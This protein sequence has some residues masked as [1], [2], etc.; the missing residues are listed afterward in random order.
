MLSG[1]EFEA[2]DLTAQ[3]A[4]KLAEVVGHGP[5]RDADLAELVHH[6][7]CIQRAVLAQVAARQFPDKFRLLGETLDS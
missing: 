3:L 2:M 6:V 1:P 4:N 7:H 5:S